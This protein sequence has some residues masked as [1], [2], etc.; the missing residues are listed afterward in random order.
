MILKICN[1]CAF[2]ETKGTDVEEFSFCS[3][4][5]CYSQFSKC[6][7]KHALKLFLENQSEPNKKQE[8]GARV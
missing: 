5:N 3:R 6:I 4:E 1:K 2:H 7:S 8:H